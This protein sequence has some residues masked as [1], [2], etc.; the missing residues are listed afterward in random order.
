MLYKKIESEVKVRYFIWVKYLM[1]T[2]LFL[3]VVIQSIILALPLIVESQIKARL[4]DEI[5]ELEPDFSVEDI[6]LT[7]TILRDLRLGNGLTIDLAELRYQWKGA[8]DFKLKKV[9]VSGLCLDLVLDDS[10]RVRFNERVFPPNKNL[11]NKGEA[12]GKKNEPLSWQDLLDFFPL[13]PEEIRIKNSDV[14]IEGKQGKIRIP[15]NLMVRLDA[16][17]G[18]GDIRLG[19]SPLGQS[20]ELIAALDLK[21]AIEQGLNKAVAQIEA[22]VHGFNP[23]CLTLLFPNIFQGFTPAGPLD[24]IVSRQGPGPWLFNVSGG[25]VRAWGLPQMRLVQFSGEVNGF[26]LK[27][28]GDM[29]LRDGGLSDFG[30]NFRFT[31]GVEPGSE[32]VFDLSFK[33]HDKDE[34][35][36]DLTRAGWIP[37][38]RG[39]PEKII[40]ARPRLS[41]NVKGTMSRQNCNLEFTGQSLGVNS[42]A[43]NSSAG[44]LGVKEVSL[45]AGLN[46]MGNGLFPIES[47]QIEFKAKALALQ[48]KGAGLRSR[49]VN[50]K[51]EIK[52]DYK[53]KKLSIGFDGALAGIRSVSA[54]STLAMDR[55]GVTGRVILDQAYVPSVRL[56]AKV[57]NA[58]LDLRDQGIAVS[59]MDIRLPTTYPFRPETRPGTLVVK[60]LTYDKR[61]SAGLSADLIQTRDMGGTLIGKIS[62]REIPDL[63]LDLALEAGA[64]QVGPSSF[65]PWTQ[66]T[67]VSSHFVL[68]GDDVARLLPGT[69][70]PG[71]F[72]TEISSEIRISLKDHALDTHGYIRV[73]EGNLDF[74]D[75]DLKAQGITG[76]IDFNDLLVP[77]SLPGQ[78]IFV[79]SV[80]AGQFRF[81]DGAIRFSIED[82]RSL[83]IENLTF[84]WCNGLVSTESLRLPAVDDR[85]FLTLYCDR[86]EMDSLLQQIGAFDARGGGTLNGRIPVVYDKGE[87]SF[88]NGFLFSTPGRGG[89]VFVK[90][91][92]RML[93][94][95]PRDTPEF[96]QLDLAGEALKDFQYEW[97]KLSMNTKGDTLD[98]RMELDG[99]PS[100]V[101][102]FEYRKNVNSF[103]RVDASS[104]GSRFQGVKLDVN[105]KL[106]FNRVMKFGNKLKSILE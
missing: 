3:V 23:A 55:G 86:L 42:S 45:T 76:Q 14:N 49:A 26:H 6:G 41:L 33:S 67:L 19:L 52:Q 1:M 64:D 88:D 77:E 95:F 53:N 38:N 74:P 11:E 79:K 61:F 30:L 48:L 65:V 7:R 102:P 43:V 83:N 62:S 99:K 105:L 5:R 63:I 8:K 78:A 18:R 15:G 12:S 20:L 90:D 50:I 70:M 9:I 100:G 10:N 36:L 106:P 2:C 39:M 28:T 92:D 98:V 84:K 101:L 31:A 66:I 4:P 24:V 29:E 82:G 27:G 97:A 93:D 51:A 40:I 32:P 87:I 57:R 81:D 22:R 71:T 103:M 35:A 16:N 25:T 60:A 54:S 34:L 44:T 37:Q 75:L 17:R 13:I 69:P 85:I 104:P 89:R 68:T 91:L 73:H 94:G 80:N 59:G 72:Q 46:R 47:G 21:A 96:S 58:G 56:V